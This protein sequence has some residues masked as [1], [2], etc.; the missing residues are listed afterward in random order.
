METLIVVFSCLTVGAGIGAYTAYQYWAVGIKLYQGSR[1]GRY[2]I[3]IADPENPR[4]FEAAM[5]LARGN[6]ELEIMRE[7]QAIED[8]RAKLKVVS[9]D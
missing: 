4:Q 7:K 3:I 8:N 5:A 9:D 2:N 6:T 1:E